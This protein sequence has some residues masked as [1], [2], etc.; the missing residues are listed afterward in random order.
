MTEPQ[1]KN[2]SVFLFS[3]AAARF[4]SILKSKDRRYSMQKEEERIDSAHLDS[5]VPPSEEDRKSVAADTARNPPKH[6]ELHNHP[7][8]ITTNAAAPVEELENKRH[9]QCVADEFS[10]TKPGRP[11]AIREP[12]AAVYELYWNNPYLIPTHYGFDTDTAQE[13]A[14]SDIRTHDSVDHAEAVNVEPAES[15]QFTPGEAN[16]LVRPVIDER[17]SSRGTYTTLQNGERKTDFSKPTCCNPSRSS[18]LHVTE[19][20]TLADIVATESPRKDSFTSPS[21]SHRATWPLAQTE[22]ADIEQYISAPWRRRTF[23]APGERVFK[24]LEALQ[25]NIF[26]EESKVSTNTPIMPPKQMSTSH[27]NATDRMLS[28]PTEKPPMSVREEAFQTWAAEYPEEAASYPS[29]SALIRAKLQEEKSGSLAQNSQTARSTNPPEPFSFSY[30]DPEYSDSEYAASGA[31]SD[32]YSEVED[33]AA[34]A[35]DVIKD[36]IRRKGDYKLSSPFFRRA[37]ATTV[38]LDA[39]PPGLGEELHVP[40]RRSKIPTALPPRLGDYTW[41]RGRVTDPAL[42]DIFSRNNPVQGDIAK[43]VIE[44]KKV[45]STTVDGLE[46]L[47]V[48]DRRLRKAREIAT[49]ERIALGQQVKKIKKNLEDMRK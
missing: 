25:E 31:E 28:P 17:T 21:P 3:K 36:E 26:P 41:E 49:A 47:D 16:N 8:L 1:H 13:E 4:K 42:V 24:K 30:K 23:T 46:P 29:E 39:T 35:Q 45:T 27:Q 2:N 40:I 7:S 38:K 37:L 20:K 34:V 14:Q 48:L 15:E 5:L 44:D 18:Q 32:T 33:N 6:E 10:S 22:K 12:S 11:L 19:N 9:G 43:R